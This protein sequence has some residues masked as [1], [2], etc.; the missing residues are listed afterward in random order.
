MRQKL[1]FSA[2]QGAI[3]SLTEALDVVRESSWF[4]QQKQAVKNTLIAGVIQNFE[5]V[6]ELSIK[7]LKRQM[8]LEAASPEDIDF[9][10][11]R[12]LLRTATEKGLVQ[13][14]DAWFQYRQLRNITSH[15]YNHEKAQQVY[16]MTIAFLIDAKALLQKLEQRDE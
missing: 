10:S 4:N 9:T 1:D 11:F 6:Y 13:N 2:L 12:G 5:F 3:I 7:M 16:Q 8:E 14:I 15:T